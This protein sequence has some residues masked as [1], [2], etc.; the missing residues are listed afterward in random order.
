MKRLIAAFHNS[1]RALNHL[2]R[3]EAA[4]RLELVLFFLSIPAAFLL[5]RTPSLA[6]ILIASIVVLI[7]VEV[8]N[9][10]I[11]AACDAVTREIDENIRIAKDCGSLAVLIA[12]VLAAGTWLYALADRL[13]N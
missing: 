12:T 7:L 11:E 1:R 9:T 4:I 8:L 5:A 2:A 10:A 6:L 13:F 3:N